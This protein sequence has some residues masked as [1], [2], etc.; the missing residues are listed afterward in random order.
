MYLLVSTLVLGLLGTLALGMQLGVRERAQMVRDQLA[1]LQSQSLASSGIELT[2]CLLAS[3][4]TPEFDTLGDLWRANGPLELSTPTGMIRLGGKVEPDPPFPV[5]WDEESKAR[6]R[7][8]DK[9][10]LRSLE[11]AA[12]ALR[13]EVAR[14]DST[15]FGNFG[16]IAHAGIIGLTRQDAFE[17]SRDLSVAEGSLNLNTAST[18]ALELA[19]LPEP[20][21]VQIQRFREGMDGEI[22][23]EDDGVFVGT[24]DLAGQMSRRIAL[25]SQDIS[26][27][28]RFEAEYPLSVSSSAFTV[29]STGF[30][31]GERARTTIVAELE[32]TEGRTQIVDWVQ[33]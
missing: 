2:R 11:T 9:N 32:R 5:V 23:T 28:T 27:L 14:L 20:L 12:L 33:L 21:A 8:L 3:D 18:V 26:R 31:V 4:P 1:R 13:L 10:Q 30:S 16:L 29:W 6:V 25:S 17:V 19:G 15:A 24:R 22:G 7:R